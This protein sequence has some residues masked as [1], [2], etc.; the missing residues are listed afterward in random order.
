M[1]SVVHC[2]CVSGVQPPA[3]SRTQ[4]QYAF[5]PNIYFI[6]TNFYI[7]ITIILGNINIPFFK[8]FFG[9]VNF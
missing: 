4:W 3:V 1:A 9:L 7:S 8:F 5:T 2:Q 6:N